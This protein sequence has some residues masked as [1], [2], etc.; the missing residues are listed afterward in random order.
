MD[1]DESARAAFLADQQAAEEESATREETAWRLNVRNG[2]ANALQ[3]EAHAMH[4][5]A[6]AKFWEALGGLIYVAT[7]LGVC[8]VLWWVIAF[9]VQAVR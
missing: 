8:A 3:A 6:K 9:I 7:T 4:M 5:A 2:D 1:H